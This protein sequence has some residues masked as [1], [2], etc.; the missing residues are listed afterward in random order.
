VA[1]AVSVVYL[2]L[3]VLPRRWFQN[4]QSKLS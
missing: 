4:V 1:S 2:A 3:L